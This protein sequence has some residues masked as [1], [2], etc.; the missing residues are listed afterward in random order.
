MTVDK[1]GNIQHPHPQQPPHKHSRKKICFR[2]KSV[3]VKFLIGWWSREEETFDVI[4]ATKMLKINK[5]QRHQDLN[6]ES[7]GV[8]MAQRINNLEKFQCDYKNSL[9]IYKTNQACNFLKVKRYLK[10]SVIP[11]SE[12]ITETSLLLLSQLC[13]LYI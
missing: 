3:E 11:L 5:N 12:Q 7:R 2:P 13:Q 8:E 4:W 6:R 10:I 1:T 9:K